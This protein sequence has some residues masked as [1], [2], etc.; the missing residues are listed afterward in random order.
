MSRIW[1]LYKKEVGAYFNSPIAYL[2]LIALLIGVGYFFI[3]PF[4]AAQQASMRIFFRF[5]AWSFLLFGPAIT[6]KQIAEEKK[7]GTIEFL[8]TLPVHEYET[9]LASFSRRGSSRPWRSP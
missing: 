5:A 3:Q 7:S 2:V 1:A 4:F 8:L 6:M 9:V